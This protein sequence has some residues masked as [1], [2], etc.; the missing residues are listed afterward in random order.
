MTVNESKHLETGRKS[1]E[2]L[3]SHLHHHLYQE[4]SHERG[5]V[6]AAT[7]LHSRWS[8]SSQVIVDKPPSQPPSC[9]PRSVASVKESHQRLEDAQTSKFG[10]LQR[11]DS[12]LWT[13]SGA[14]TT[15]GRP[16]LRRGKAFRRLP[17]GA[18]TTT[19]RPPFR[20]GKPFRGFHH[21]ACRW[22]PSSRSI[23]D[24]VP[25]PPAR[26]RRVIVGVSN[27]FSLLDPSLELKDR[28]G[29]KLFWHG[30][31]IIFSVF[32]QFSVSGLT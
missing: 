1:N 10:R 21:G 15:T 30:R 5:S 8:S 24:K 4:S 32:R 31:C 25:T 18:G 20:R 28:D 11:S 16:P 14:G 27:T 3:H 13:S 17:H 26:A 19:D 6:P 2:T 29:A 7:S 22:F 23:F 12:K 9:S